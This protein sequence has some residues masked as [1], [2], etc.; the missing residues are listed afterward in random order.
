MVTREVTQTAASWVPEHADVE[1][2]RRTAED[3]RGCEL[4][5]PATQVVFS[6]GNPRAPW[7]LS[8]NNP[9]DRGRPQR[10]SLFGPAG[11]LLQDALSEDEVRQDD[12]YVPNA[13]KH[14]R[15]TER[16]VRGAHCRPA[17]RPSSGDVAA[18]GLDRVI[19]PFR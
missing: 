16:G 17:N 5:E 6:A 2:L 19:E 14:F 7:R 15:F 4:W 10:H 13:V 9:A 18:E 12:V 8:E 11:R 1:K 3:C